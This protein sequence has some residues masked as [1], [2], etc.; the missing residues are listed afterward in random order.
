[1]AYEVGVGILVVVLGGENGE[2]PKIVGHDDLP[3]P[4]TPERQK[5]SKALHSPN[6]NCPDGADE[7]CTV[8]LDGIEKSWR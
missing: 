1:M 5:T 3:A 7:S 4:K 2:E 6:G 8:P